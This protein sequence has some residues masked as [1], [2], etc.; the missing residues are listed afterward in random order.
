MKD[1][2]VSRFGSATFSWVQVLW[3][4]VLKLGIYGAK[5]LKNQRRPAFLPT[6]SK[7][8]TSFVPNV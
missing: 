2:G 4:R 7:P 8:S 6:N 1:Y 5:D 3:F